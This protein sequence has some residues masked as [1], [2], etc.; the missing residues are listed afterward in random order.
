M[1][2]LRAELDRYLSIRRALGFT[3]VRAER[4]LNDFIDWLHAG[5]TSSGIITTH[6]AVAW[7]SLPSGASPDWW[8]QR[9]SVVRG[10]ARHLHAIDQVH[11]VPPPGLLP[12]RTRRATPWLYSDADIAALM[13]AAGQL[14]S[15]LRAATFTTLIG[16]LAVTGLRIGEALRL[17]RCDVDLSDGMLHIRNTKFGKSRY[18]PLHPSAR[19]ALAAYTRRRDQ[20]CPHPADPSFLVSTVGTRLLYCNAHAVWLDL[21]SRAGLHA[22]SARCR[23][24]PHDLRHYADGRVMCPAGVFGLVRAV[25]AVLLSA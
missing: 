5:G 3:L 4:L 11:E 19:D 24:R 16:L 7:A 6:D 22:R 20:L 1:T 23:P 17:D 9:L 13:T 15:P 10:F 25:P 18:V 8:G 2:D 21:I 14:R 12:A